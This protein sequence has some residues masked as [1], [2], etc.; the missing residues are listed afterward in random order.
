MYLYVKNI[1]IKKI[2]NDKNL[3]IKK[4]YNDIKNIAIKKISSITGLKERSPPEPT[5]RLLSSL[6]TLFT[7]FLILWF[8][9]IGPLMGILNDT[10]QWMGEKG[11]KKKIKMS[12]L[13]LKSLFHCQHARKRSI[14]FSRISLHGC[15]QHKKSKVQSLYHFCFDSVVTLMPRYSPNQR[16]QTVLNKKKP[17][18]PLQNII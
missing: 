11:L 10:M 8:F 12:W 15:F 16:H 5:L 1:V 7:I 9:L 13:Q 18:I 3:A 4:I 2:Y 17:L 14:V 6:F